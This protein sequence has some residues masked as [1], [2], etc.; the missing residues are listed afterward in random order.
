MYPHTLDD[1]F[2]THP[3]VAHDGDVEQREGEVV[4]QELEQRAHAVQP[5]LYRTQGAQGP[6]QSMIGWA[7]E[8]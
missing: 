1:P 8:R 5:H 2:F 4:L 6:V 3:Q 7:S